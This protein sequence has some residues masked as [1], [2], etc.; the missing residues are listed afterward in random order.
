MVYISWFAFVDGQK[1]EIL[2]S[3]KPKMGIEKTSWGRLRVRRLTAH[4]SRSP[5]VLGE[6][7]GRKGV[8]IN[9]G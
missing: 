6:V 2:F 7:V 4:G 5:S 8:R 1:E 3:R 9:T